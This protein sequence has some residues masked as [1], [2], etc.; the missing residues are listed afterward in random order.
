MSGISG[1]YFL[2]PK[3][4]FLTPES[5][6]V[7]LDAHLKFQEV[8]KVAYDGKL[9]EH[10]FIDECTQW[11]APNADIKKAFKNHKK[12]RFVSKRK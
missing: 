10:L 5:A 12:V 11:V 3:G 9:M 6:V 7:P 8:E 2:I 4:K 1:C